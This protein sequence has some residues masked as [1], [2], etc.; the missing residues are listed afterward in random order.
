MDQSA[1]SNKRGFK[2]TMYDEL[3]KKLEDISI[4]QDWGGELVT[5]TAQTL[6]PEEAIG[7]P[8][9]DDYPILK[10]KERIV[11]A[12]FHGA[13][14]HAFTDMFGNYQGTLDQI[15]SMKPTNN[16]RRATF[17]ATLN[18]VL[19][20]L[21]MVEKTVHCRDGAPQECGRLL[22][23]EIKSTYGEPKIALVG[24]QPR[25]AQALAEQFPLRITDLDA[26][27]IGTKKFG[28]EVQG[29]EHTEEN[30]DWCDLLVVTGS[31]AVNDTMQ[32]FMGRKPVIFFGVTV[33]GP[34]YLLGLKQFCPLGM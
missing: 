8:E 30:V 25:M 11:E 9:E 29:P 24:L 19:R 27:N 15:V 7:N 20:S 31:T 10:G 14:G 4:E 33:A 12:V 22:V 6:T 13:R 5:V 21:G 26:E 16:F 17:I 2:E 28:I 18:A 32:Q 23:E 34:A 3:C 1:L